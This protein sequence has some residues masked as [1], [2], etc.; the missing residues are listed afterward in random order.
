MLEKGER[1][2]VKESLQR[3]REN[4]NVRRMKEKPFWAIV[5]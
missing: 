3:E 2:T 1:L 5:N 4:E